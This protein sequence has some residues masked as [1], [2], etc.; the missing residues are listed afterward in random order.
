MCVFTTMLYFCFISLCNLLQIRDTLN[1]VEQV[2]LSGMESDLVELYS[3]GPN[4]E[5]LE[6]K[7]TVAVQ[8]CLGKTIL[9]YF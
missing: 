5:E 3:L 4:L 6:W 7:L 8:V 1:N 9:T 2:S